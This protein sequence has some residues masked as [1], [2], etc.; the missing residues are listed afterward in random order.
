M[1]LLS[2]DERMNVLN[3]EGSQSTPSII[4][5]WNYTP[6]PYWGQFVRDALKGKR[7]VSEQTW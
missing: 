3:I 2:G 6:T 4:A 1:R 7:F 5:D